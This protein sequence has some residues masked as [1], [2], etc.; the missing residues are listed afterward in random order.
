M[1]FRQTLSER[2]GRLSPAVSLPR[3]PRQIPFHHCR[4][5]VL[6]T[7]DVS[8]GEGFSQSVSPGNSIPETEALQ[9]IESD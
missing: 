2:T 7:C 4:H 1:R 6:G 9:L 3:G 5:K 8:R